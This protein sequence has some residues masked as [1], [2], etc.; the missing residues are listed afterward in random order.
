MNVEQAYQLR[1]T[2][3]H[4]R[5]S[6]HN[7]KRK[8]LGL[9]RLISFLSAV[10]L[11]FILL[12]L[13]II[14]A[15][16]VAIVLLTI[17]LVVTLKDISNL[18]K[19]R[20]L[21]QLVLINEE[22]QKALRGDFS[23]FGEGGEFEDRRHPYASDLDIFGQHSIFQMLN[24]TT[25]FRSAQLLAH[26]LKETASRKTILNRQQAIQALAPEIKWRQRLQALGRH[27]N[28]HQSDFE[29]I[30]TWAGQVPDKDQLSK[31]ST[32]T[33][34]VGG[35]TVMLIVLASLNVI[36]WQALWIS[37][38]AHLYVIWRVG[39]II[40]PHY[41][42]LSQTMASMEALEQ[43]LCLIS[44]KSFG[45]PQ[46][47]HLQ[48]RLARNDRQAFQSIR[49]LKKVM[50]K[51]EIRFNPLVHFPLNLIFFW[52]WYQFK[53]LVNWQERI[54]ADLSDWIAVFVEIEALCSLANLS[55]NHPE[56]CFP[57]ITDA[58]FRLQAEELGHPLIVK[59]SRVCNDM[60]LEGVGKL[61]LITGSNMAGKSTFLRTVGVNIVLGMA[62]A[63]VCAKRMI[64][65]PVKVISSMRIADNL[66][67]NTS[68]FYAELKKLEFIIQVSKRKE[69]CL[70]LMDE[71][72]RGTN[73][74]DRHTG[75][76]AL[77]EQLLKVH[78]VG[79]LATHDLALTDMEV[80][81][82]GKVN[83][84][85]FDVQVQQEELFFDYK[86]KEGV[87]RS[88]NASLLMRKIGI[89]L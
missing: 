63:P 44:T 37:L 58:H 46:L 29:Q 27:K 76:R 11:F 73:S 68:T 13:H 6:L 33:V 57:E 66:E 42:L 52:D 24:R 28:I 12:T 64:V 80:L 10:L 15:T 60:T 49:A 75:S 77:I 55:Y 26:W 53:A 14:V 21:E 88:M 20:F 71:I 39:K 7:K 23:A 38:I 62:G 2:E 87:C 85:H 43:R 69:K 41:N 61:M 35:M 54:S 30:L 17:F 70:L 40:K 3:L 45:E 84:Y 16:I 5:L 36:P 83:N 74:N 51:L 56:W 89:E 65:S 81:N 4:R 25:T 47:Q 34:M 22:E 78:A 72:L 8:R 82:P 9:A 18:K 1:L 48:A 32:G 31:W 50:E 86:L 59:G 19:I 79:I 67:E